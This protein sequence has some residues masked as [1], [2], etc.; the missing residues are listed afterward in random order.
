[1]INNDDKKQAS[2]EQGFLDIQL[3]CTPKTK[4]S[5]AIKNETLL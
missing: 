4:V 1:M 5:E 3:Q 2:Q